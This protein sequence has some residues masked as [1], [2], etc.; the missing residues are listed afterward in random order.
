MGDRGISLQAAAILA[1]VTL[2]DGAAIYGAVVAS[3]VAAWQLI[4]YWQSHRPKLLI[5][6]GLYVYLKGEKEAEVF[7]RALEGEG[8]SAEGPPFK[9]VLRVVNSGRVRVHLSSLALVQ[10]RDRQSR[11]WNVGPWINLPLWLEPGEAVPV[12]LTESE[13][14]D[15]SFTLPIETTAHTS[16]GRCFRHRLPVIGTSKDDD[17]KVVLGSALYHEMI[18]RDPFPHKLRYMHSVRRED[19]EKPAAR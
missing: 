18:Q 3:A 7:D 19:G 1:L 17:I 8:D 14:P 2:A 10:V 4:T 16:T 6:T 5:R 15:F 12:T 13:L 9:I 11:Q